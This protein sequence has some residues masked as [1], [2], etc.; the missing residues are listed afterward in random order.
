MQTSISTRSRHRVRTGEMRP[1]RQTDAAR[2]R[3]GDADFLS[4][5][6][7]LQNAIE[8]AC[9]GQEPWEAKVASGIRAALDCIAEHPQMARA[10]TIQARGERSRVGE[11]QQEAIVHFGRLL[12]GVAPKGG[13]PISS[14]VGTIDAIATVVRGSLE[15]GRAQELTSL[16][17]D[18]IFLALLPYVSVEEAQ[19][20]AGS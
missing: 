20:W 19:Q 16:A 10:L 2:I 15:N 1:A 8:A 12:R 5:F 3:A 14:A 13:R 9:V 7:R 6:A 18:L 11:R 4:S 17:P